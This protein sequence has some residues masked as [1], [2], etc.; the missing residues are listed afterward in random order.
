MV[1]L[2]AH[3]GVGGIDER[4]PDTSSLQRRFDVPAL[5][6]RHRRGPAAGRVLAIVQFEEA[7]DSA[8]DLCD[9]DNRSLSR[10]LEILP[11]LS[12]VIRKAPGP[13]G[14]AQANPVDAV[15]LNDLA[16]RHQ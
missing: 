9:K 3:A 12:V 15:A 4:S 11:G 2:R 1:S 14:V 8:I 16:N 6:E 5:D 13:Q 7:D 10:L